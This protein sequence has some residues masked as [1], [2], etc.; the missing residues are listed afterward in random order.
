MAK[1]TRSDES[2][3]AR[4][5]RR[6]VPGGGTA[7]AEREQARSQPGEDVRPQLREDAQIPAE[8]PNASVS[9]GPS[10]DAIARRAFEIYQER[11]GGDGLEVQDWLRAEAELTRGRQQRRS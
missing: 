10:P 6:E 9:E 2:G 3:R 4:G 8:A 7:L 5:G 1:N 11:G